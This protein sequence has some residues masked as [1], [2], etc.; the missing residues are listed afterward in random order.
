MST[1]AAGFYGSVWW[2]V[3]WG[4]LLVVA[5]VVYVTIKKKQKQ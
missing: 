5:I 1:L 2:F 3:M 4:A